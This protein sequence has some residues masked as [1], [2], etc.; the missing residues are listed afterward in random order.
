M[1]DFTST[2]LHHLGVPLFCLLYLMLRQVNSLDV[3]NLE[4]PHDGAHDTLRHKQNI[5]ARA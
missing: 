4:T 1:Q 5:A 2:L 3:A